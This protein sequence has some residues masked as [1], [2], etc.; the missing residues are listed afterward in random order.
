MGITNRLARLSLNFRNVIWPAG[1]I[2]RETCLREQFCLLA[3]E[4]VLMGLAALLTLAAAP[5]YLVTLVKYL[6]GATLVG[7]YASISTRRLH[8]L[9]RSGWALLKWYGTLFV[10]YQAAVFTPKLAMEFD[11]LTRGQAI[12]LLVAEGVF[13]IGV[14]MHLVYTVFIKDGA[15]GDNR[16]GAPES[17]VAVGLS[18]A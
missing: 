4:G 16:F 5:E 6:I 17:G 3:L 9:G 10:V 13:G 2:G 1:R 7:L 18:P 8:D 14:C 12:A 15:Q 11:Y